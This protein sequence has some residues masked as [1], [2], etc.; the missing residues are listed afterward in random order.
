MVKFVLA[1]LSL[2]TLS[3]FALTDAY[4][5]CKKIN[6]KALLDESWVWRFVFSK[7]QILIQCYN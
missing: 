5:P 4:K 7:A 6:N 1:G 3:F 2:L